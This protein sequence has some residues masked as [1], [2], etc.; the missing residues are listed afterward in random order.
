MSQYK[1]Q[2]KDISWIKKDIKIAFI[3]AEFNKHYTEALETI[4]ID[5]L[6]EQGFKNTSSFY[7]PWAFEIPWMLKRVLKLKKYDL[8]ITFGVVI[9]WET[10]HFDYVCG[11]SARAIMNI[12]V[13]NK[14][15]IIFGILTCNTEKQVEERISPTYAISGLNLI[16]E[17]A[18]L[19]DK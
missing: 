13:K 1:S 8:I 10:P 12:T 3:T 4:N 17:C 19:K 9:R 14:T 5:F 2:L 7:V 11:E 16:A 6:K 15:P 18:K